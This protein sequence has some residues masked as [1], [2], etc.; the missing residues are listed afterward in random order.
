MYLT[1]PME[2]LDDYQ[3][4]KMN[5]QIKDKNKIRCDKVSDYLGSSG[6]KN[7]IHNSV[8]VGEMNKDIGKPNN[9]N[10]GLGL[11]KNVLPEKPRKYFDSYYADGKG[12][13]R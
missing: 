13:Y 11:N 8:N 7:I 9:R 12:Y 6:I 2:T 3:C 5:S 1:N 4:S 10:E